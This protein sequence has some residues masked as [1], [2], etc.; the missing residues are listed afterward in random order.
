MQDL[1]GMKT[2]LDAARRFRWK[3]SFI[4]RTFGPS[5]HLAIKIHRVSHYRIYINTV[6]ASTRDET[7]QRQVHSIVKLSKKAKLQ[8]EERQ[9]LCL[10]LQRRSLP[11]LSH[12]ASLPPRLQHYSMLLP[13]R[14]PES[15]GSGSARMLCVEEAHVCA[16]MNGCV[17]VEAAL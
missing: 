15:L 17:S 11:G 10:A 4:G 9:L 5:R 8:T 7:R 3:S 1:P 14:C 16:I 13:S 6:C 12:A 2:C